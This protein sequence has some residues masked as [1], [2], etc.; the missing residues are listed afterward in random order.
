MQDSATAIAVLPP[1]LKPGF[2][3]RRK[4]SLDA[5]FW[6]LGRPGRLM[7]PGATLADL[8]A[9]DHLVGLAQDMMRPALRLATRARLSLILAEPA[10]IHAA[11]QRQVARAA[12]RYHRVLTCNETM[13]ARIENGIF[14]PYGNTWVPEWRDLDVAKTAMCSLIASGKRSQDGHALRHALAR[15]VADEG[16]DV[17]L[18]GHGYRPFYHKAEGLVPYRYSVVIENVSERNFFTEKLID[19]ILCQTVPIYW[20]CPNIADFMDVSGMILCATE[21]DLQAA[22]RTMSEADYAARLPGLKAA[23]P[24]AAAYGDIFERAAMAV[25]DDCPVPPGVPSPAI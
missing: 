1:G 9:R 7:K 21:A 17:D 22:L 4:V 2:M 13:L 8:D 16:L 3:R 24:R 25:R 23:Q 15:H 5:L 14:F 19:A 18:I 11:R 10:A 12:H 6:P 20:G